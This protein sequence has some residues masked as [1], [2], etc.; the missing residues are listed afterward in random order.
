MGEFPVMAVSELWLSVRTLI[1]AISCLHKQIICHIKISCKNIINNIY[2]DL[3]LL[4]LPPN[5]K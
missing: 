2:R 1:L 5:T 4:T 3:P